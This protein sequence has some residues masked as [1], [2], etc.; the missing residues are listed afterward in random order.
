M[1]AS[2]STSSPNAP[3]EPNR[4]GKPFATAAHPNACQDPRR[5]SP[6]TTSSSPK[7]SSNDSQ[8]SRHKKESHDQRPVRLHQRNPDQQAGAPASNDPRHRR[9]RHRNE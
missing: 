1:T 2:S 7:K 6:T 3:K 4:S 5:H 9:R 8:T